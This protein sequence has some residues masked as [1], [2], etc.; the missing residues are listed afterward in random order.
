LPGLVPRRRRLFVNF[1]CRL[2]RQKRQRVLEVASL[3]AQSRRSN[4]V[5]EQTRLSL[6]ESVRRCSVYPRDTQSR[7]T[8]A[9]SPINSSKGFGAAC[10]CHTKSSCRGPRV[11]QI[12]PS[13]AANGNAGG[14]CERCGVPG[15]RPRGLCK[16]AASPRERRRAR[17]TTVTARPSHAD[18]R[19]RSG[20]ENGPHDG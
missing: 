5:T 1:A 18:P 3:L 16:W 6:A 2:T 8:S 13:H 17:L 15:Q 4:R 20:P 9:G 11:R 12:V 14:H 10:R 19:V 7:T